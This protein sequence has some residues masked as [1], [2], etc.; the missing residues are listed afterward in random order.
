M[1]SKV[2]RKYRN[3]AMKAAMISEMHKKYKSKAPKMSGTQQQ[4]Q[5]KIK[6]RRSFSK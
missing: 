1:K 4:Q 3:A 6:L 2:P 5:K